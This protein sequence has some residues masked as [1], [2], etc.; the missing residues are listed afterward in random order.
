MARITCPSLSFRRDPM[1]NLLFR[2]RYCQI[3]VVS[4]NE[5][6]QFRTES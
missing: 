6:S 1:S 5:D 2:F 4:Y 3:K